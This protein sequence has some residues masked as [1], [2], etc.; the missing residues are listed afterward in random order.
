MCF[1]PL[2]V[3]GAAWRIQRKAAARLEDAEH[4]MLQTIEIAIDY[5]LDEVDRHDLV[6]VIVGEISKRRG[7]RLNEFNIWKAFCALARWILTQ[8]DIS[9]P[10]IRTTSFAL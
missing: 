7:V 8:R 4:L 1:Q 6:R 2:D 5:M 10:A 3:M 9:P